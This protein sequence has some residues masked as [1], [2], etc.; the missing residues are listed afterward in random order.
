MRVVGYDFAEG[1]R[2]MEDKQTPAKRTT[3]EAAKG[4][5]YE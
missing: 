2:A 5:T 1:K 3:G 4:F